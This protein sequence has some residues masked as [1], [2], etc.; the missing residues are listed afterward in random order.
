MPN[1]G[2]GARGEYDGKLTVRGQCAGQERVDQKDQE[3]LLL[4]ATT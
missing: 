1:A 4:Q 2:E 3:Y